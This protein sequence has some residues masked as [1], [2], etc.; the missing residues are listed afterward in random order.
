MILDAPLSSQFRSIFHSGA[1]VG[2]PMP[3]KRQGEAEE[4]E[5]VLPTPHPAVVRV[6][7]GGSCYAVYALS[8]LRC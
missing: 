8:Y 6:R 3:V 7:I 5:T 4:G 1:L 2:C